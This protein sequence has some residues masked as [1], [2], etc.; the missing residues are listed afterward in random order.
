M[1]VTHYIPSITPTAAPP[2]TT[3]HIASLHESILTK[4]VQGCYQCARRR[5]DCDG[6]RPRCRKCETRGL[7]CDRLGINFRFCDGVASRG[8][9]VGKHVPN[10]LSYQRTV[11]SRIPTNVPTRDVH[12]SLPSTAPNADSGVSGASPTGAGSVTEH[13]DTHSAWVSSHIG[14][15]SGKDKQG[16]R[17]ASDRQTSWVDPA[18]DTIDATTRWYLQYCKPY[19][20]SMSCLR[21]FY[22]MRR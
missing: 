7:T 19:S 2:L 6:A 16:L 12:E 8:K 17:P 14:S 11:P 4:I 1:R 10:I 20:P 15:I 13:T 3:N 21:G 18:L 9:L 5:I 22:A